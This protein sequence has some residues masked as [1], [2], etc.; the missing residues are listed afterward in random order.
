MEVLCHDPASSNNNGHP[1]GVR[2]LY[3]MCLSSSSEAVESRGIIRKLLLVAHLIPPFMIPGS[4]TESQDGTVQLSESSLRDSD[5][6]NKTIR[7][8]KNWLLKSAVVG[9]QELNTV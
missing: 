8:K 9:Y 7:K 1:L 6:T 5:L 2:V 4:M 3:R